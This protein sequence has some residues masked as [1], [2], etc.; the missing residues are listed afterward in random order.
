[1]LVAIA[2]PL[3]ALAAVIVANVLSGITEIKTKG[4]TV[5]RKD[6]DHPKG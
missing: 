5:S 2:F 6:N 1:M 3:V 4:S